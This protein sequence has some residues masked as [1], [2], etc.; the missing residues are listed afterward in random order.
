MFVVS[1]LLKEEIPGARTHTHI[2]TH[3]QVKKHR[4][5]Q[6]NKDLLCMSCRFSVNTCASVHMCVS[7]RFAEEAGWGCSPEEEGEAGWDSTEC[8]SFTLSS[9]III[10]GGIILA[11]WRKTLI[12]FPLDFLNQGS[13]SCPRAQIHTDP[14]WIVRHA[15]I[16]GRVW[17]CVSHDVQINKEKKWFKAIS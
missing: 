13:C 4:H 17:W 7:W 6:K 3:I 15:K 12:F 2:L 14:L 5:V 8:S 16:K 10:G 1:K 9:I 11:A